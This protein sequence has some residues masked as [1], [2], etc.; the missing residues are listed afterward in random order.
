MTTIK[1]LRQQVKEQT[2]CSNAKEIKAAYPQYQGDDFRCKAT[3]QKVADETSQPAHVIDLLEARFHRELE[4]DNFQAA[5]DTAL[6]Q[7]E[8]DRKS[9]K[10]RTDNLIKLIRSKKR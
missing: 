5:S 6:F 8:Q 4:N 10:E 1:Q 9:L 7:L 2:G 3:M